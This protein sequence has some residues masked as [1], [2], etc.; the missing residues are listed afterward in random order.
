MRIETIELLRVELPLRAPFRAAHGTETVRDVLLVRVATTDGAVGWGEC[1]ASRTAGYTTEYTELAHATIREQL[2]P[3][4]LAA[5]IVQ[6]EIPAV[7]GDAAP[8]PMAT[9]AVE[10]A[11]VDAALSRSGLGA[12]DVLGATRDR[13]V[14]T[15]AL[16][17][18]VSIPALCTAAAA[19]VEAGYRSLKLKIRPGWDV[20]PIR[21]VRSLAPEVAIRV[22]ANGAYDPADVDTLLGLDAH[23]VELIEQPFAPTELV[24]SAELDA[25]ARADVALDE[26]IVDE[27]SLE[28]AIEAE[29]C[30]VVNLKAARVGGLGVARRL[31]DRARD[32]GV[33]LLA[34]GM[35][36]TGIGRAGALAV[37]ALPGCTRAADLAASDHYWQRDLTEPFVLD[38][39]GRLTVSAGPGLGAVVDEMRVDEVVR[40][41]ER[42]E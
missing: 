39:H 26:S 35:L 38:G 23:D 20:E 33:E 13:I 18:D 14:A 34:G 25:R 17:I 19:A 29:A 30:S 3:R 8:H 5:P 27:A 22:D 28:A 37:A 9:A 2:V 21:A 6:G 12:F 40:T 42:F 10:M 16:G 7:L 32:A 31:H 4:V 24:A 36:E 41:R 15:A 11:L 1:A